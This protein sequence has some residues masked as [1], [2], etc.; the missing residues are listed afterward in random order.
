MNIQLILEVENSFENIVQSYL[1]ILKGHFFGTPCIQLI[2][3]IIYPTYT[4]SDAT[5]TKP[6]EPGFKHIFFHVKFF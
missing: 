6:C 5:L 1:T 2:Q 3:F 4:L